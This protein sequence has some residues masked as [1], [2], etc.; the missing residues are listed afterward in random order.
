M[1]AELAMANDDQEITFVPEPEPVAP[2]TES[3]MLSSDVEKLEE[4]QTD[5]VELKSLAGSSTAWFYRGILQGAGAIVGSILM[6]IFLGWVLSFLG[7]FPG[8]SEI[9]DYIRGYADRVTR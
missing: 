3:A 5:L 2:Q 8:F 7:F 1:C 6:L 4:I 9:A